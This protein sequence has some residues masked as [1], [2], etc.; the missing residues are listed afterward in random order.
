M[1]WRAA[2]DATLMVHFAFIVFMVL[3]GF[4]ARRR[5]AVAALHLAVVGYGVVIELAGF[6]CPLT[7]V[8]LSFRRA[9]GQAGYEGGFIEHYLVS[10]IYPGGLTFGVRAL[11]VAG[12]ILVTV[13]AYWPYLR[14]ERPAGLLAR[15]RDP[16]QVPQGR[17]HG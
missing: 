6:R 17:E 2:A 11:L 15:V 5:P 4:L 8:E 7:P 16:D 1:G 10:V 3:G 13:C 14:R 12:L 9:A